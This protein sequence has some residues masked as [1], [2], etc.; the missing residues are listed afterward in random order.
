MKNQDGGP[1]RRDANFLAE[2]KSMTRDFADR[3]V[4]PSSSLA[5]SQQLSCTLPGDVPVTI[6][7]EHIAKGTYNGTMYGTKP[8]GV[9]HFGKMTNFTKQI[10]D[11]TK[12]PSDE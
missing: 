3:H 4:A 9:S 6:Y 10:G 12:D 11:F 8:F 2:T 7:S 5:D 1:V